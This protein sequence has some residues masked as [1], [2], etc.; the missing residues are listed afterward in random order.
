[1]ELI[2]VKGK[3]N[4]SFKGLTLGMVLAIRDELADKIQADKI[5]PVAYD[6]LRFLENQDLNE[7]D[8]W[9]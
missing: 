2:K 7:K 9:S 4:Y 6:V 1:M 8:P 5:S 3:N